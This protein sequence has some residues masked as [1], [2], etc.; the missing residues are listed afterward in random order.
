MVLAAVLGLEVLGWEAGLAVAV[1]DLVGEEAFE[2]DFLEGG[3]A[4]AA[5][6]ASVAAF[7]HSGV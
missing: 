7:E 6:T 4:T 2:G 5:S 3:V 1:P